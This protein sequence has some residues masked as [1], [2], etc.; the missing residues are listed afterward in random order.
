MTK[1]SSPDA[2]TSGPAGPERAY[3]E[4]GVAAAIRKVKPSLAATDFDRGTR[5]DDLEISSLELIT[6]VFEIEDFFDIR[7]VDRNLD[8]LHSYGHACDVVGRLLAAGSA[9]GAGPA[10]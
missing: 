1:T 7:I 4:G 6:I 8:D 5:F 3:I 2:S 10:A 9:S